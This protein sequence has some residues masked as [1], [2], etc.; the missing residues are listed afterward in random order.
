MLDLTSD[1]LLYEQIQSGDPQALN[2]LFHKYYQGLCRF[3]Y[4]IV[5]EKVVAEELS[6]NVFIN[7]WENREQIFIH[8][9]LKAF[10][11]KSAQNQGISYLRKKQKNINSFE[12]SID[13]S[14]SK[15]PGPESRYIDD[16][17]KTEFEK[18]L[19]KLSPRA[20]LAFTLHRLDGLQYTEIS[21]IMDISVSAVEKNIA[22]ALKTLHKKLYHKTIAG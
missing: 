10:L 17:L 11:Y 4:V 1:I 5:R 12:N 2:L 3:T 18:A 8:T 15:D 6:A 22:S 21:D 16:E 19:S 14:D 9:S 7:L 20:R 13:L